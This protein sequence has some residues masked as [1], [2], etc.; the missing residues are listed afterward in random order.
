[1][2]QLVTVR[3]RP[4]PDLRHTWHVP[5]LPVALLLAPILVL[6]LLSGLIACVVFRINPVAALYGLARVVWALRGTTFDL[7]DGRTA[8]GISFR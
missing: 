8:F 3:Y 2:P 1:M 7:V 4:E 5:V 6:A